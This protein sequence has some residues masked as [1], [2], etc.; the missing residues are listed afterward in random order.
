MA[1][2]RALLRLAQGAGL[3]GLMLFGIVVFFLLRGERCWT[4]GAAG[5]R[6]SQG[7]AIPCPDCHG[8]GSSRSL[9][10]TLKSEGCY[11]EYLPGLRGQLVVSHEEEEIL[12]LDLYY[13]PFTLW[14][15]VTLGA[16]G[17]LVVGLTSRPCPL[18][19]GEGRL[20][21]EVALPSRP[22]HP[23]KI[24]CAACRGSG[25]ATALDR[26]LVGKQASE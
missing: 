4:C 22:T 11:W 8:T 16:A 9:T 21:I 13:L 10:M 15:A 19:S 18:C 6:V 12:R 20:M 14:S 3:L 24:C 25:Q 23:R 17:V 2:R 5:V 7:V 26:W 1:R